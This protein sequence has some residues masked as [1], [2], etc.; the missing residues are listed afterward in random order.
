MLTDE[1]HVGVLGYTL[2]IYW[3]VNISKKN[4]NF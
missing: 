2:I 1:L 4:K 3:G